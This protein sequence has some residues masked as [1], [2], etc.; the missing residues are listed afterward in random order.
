MAVYESWEERNKLQNKYR[1]CC[2]SC[3]SGVRCLEFERQ[4]TI[5]STVSIYA[6]PTLTA[7]VCSLIWENKGVDVFVVERNV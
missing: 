3:R 5:I 4:F 2:Y 6:H 7:H 1:I